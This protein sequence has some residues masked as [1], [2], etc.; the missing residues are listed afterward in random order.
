MMEAW[1]RQDEP[2]PEWFSLAFVFAVPDMFL[3]PIPLIG[4]LCV[5]AGAGFLLAWLIQHSPGFKSREGV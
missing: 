4:A 1:G 2:K 3:I 5:G